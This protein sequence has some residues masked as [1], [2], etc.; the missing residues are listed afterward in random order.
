MKVVLNKCY[1]GF[2]L[3][4]AA[5]CE[6]IS[7][8][9]PCVHGEKRDDIPEHYNIEDVPGWPGYKTNTF[10]GSLVVKDGVLYTTY[11]TG[12]SENDFRSHPD[13]L[14]VV[15]KLGA[16]ASSQLGKLEIV[17]IPDNI[18]WDIDDYDGMESIHERHR[19]W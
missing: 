11:K 3:S 14:A 1:G 13:L 17:E 4:A 15:E 8:N 7:M 19:C 18:E 16:K 9:S 10:Y 2:G 5:M 12:L 6:L